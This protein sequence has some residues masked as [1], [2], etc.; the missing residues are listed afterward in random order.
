MFTDFSQINAHSC[1]SILTP[2]REVHGTKEDISICVLRFCIILCKTYIYI[3][4]IEFIIHWSM[5]L[6]ANETMSYN[7]N[8]MSIESNYDA[9]VFQ[10]ENSK[11]MVRCTIYDN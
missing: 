7:S 11:V 10:R 5:P 6:T 4:Y 2:K 9:R 3:I 8:D 1:F